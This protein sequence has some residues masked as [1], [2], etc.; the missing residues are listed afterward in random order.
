MDDREARPAISAVDEGIAE[1]AVARVHHFAKTIGANGDFGRN[2]SFR[3]TIETAGNDAKVGVVGTFEFAWAKRGDFG[4][5]RRFGLQ[6]REELIDE[7]RFAL[8]FDGDA[9]GSVG[10]EAGET[11]VMRQAI[12]ERAKTDTLNDTGDVDG[13]AHYDGF[14]RFLHDEIIAESSGIDSGG[15]LDFVLKRVEPVQ[16][17]IEAIAGAKKGRWFPSSDGSCGR[18][19]RQGRD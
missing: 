15:L 11:A 1:A 8:N 2:E 18:C 7:L 17:K 5:R 4:Q 13:L 19:R 10:D 12:N 6:A 3:R 9:R 16:P 14:G